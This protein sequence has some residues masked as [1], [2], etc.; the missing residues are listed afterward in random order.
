MPSTVSTPEQRAK[1]AIAKKISKHRAN[2]EEI[3]YWFMLSDIDID[4][5]GDIPDLIKML[6]KLDR[7]RKREADLKEQGVLPKIS[8]KEWKTFKSWCS[9]TLRPFFI[10]YLLDSAHPK[11]PEDVASEIIEIAK[12]YDLVSKFVQSFPE[13]ARTHIIE[14]YSEISAPLPQTEAASEA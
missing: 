7:I 14:L 12:R 1:W 9:L 4:N 11:T 8:E 6:K 5:I 2:L 3:S 13:E 10:S